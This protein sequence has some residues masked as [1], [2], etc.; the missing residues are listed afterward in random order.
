MPSLKSVNIWR[1]TA[2]T[3]TGESEIG[4]VASRGSVQSEPIAVLRKGVRRAAATV[5]MLSFNATSTFMHHHS[6]G[7]DVFELLKA[8]FAGPYV[9]SH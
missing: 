8:V 2:A 7:D 4:A 9:P 1:G 3:E 6:G 5:H